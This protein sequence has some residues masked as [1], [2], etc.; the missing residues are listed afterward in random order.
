[1][2]FEIISGF[3]AVLF[4]NPLN[5]KFIVI[6]VVLVVYHRHFAGYGRSR[7]VIPASSSVGHNS[8]ACVTGKQAEKSL[9]FNV[10]EKT[11]PVDSGTFDSGEN[12][13]LKAT[14]GATR[15]KIFL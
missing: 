10:G 1:M 11:K 3:H 14:R 13:A 5:L 7:P 6:F 9:L 15:I 2:V 12:R 4:S 8:G